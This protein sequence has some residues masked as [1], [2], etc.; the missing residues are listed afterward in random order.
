MKSAQVMTQVLHT[1]PNGQ[2]LFSTK[3]E[4]P[5][6]L[7][8]LLADLIGLQSLARLARVSK[9]YNQLYKTYLDETKAKEANQ[10]AFN[11]NYAKYLFF[12]GKRSCE[13]F[14]VSKDLAQ[15]NGDKDTQ[16]YL[17]ISQLYAAFIKASDK[18]LKEIISATCEKLFNS[19]ASQLS[20]KNI[21]VA[22]KLQQL[23]MDLELIDQRP[24]FLDNPVNRRL[25]FMNSYRTLCLE[26]KGTSNEEAVRSSA[27]SAVC[28][29]L[30]TP[31]DIKKESEKNLYNDKLNEHKNYFETAIVPQKELAL[32]RI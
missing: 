19:F 30:K 29:L 25:T 28:F 26:A 10:K 15:L 14:I 5:V 18:K 3:R 4:F 11:N 23:M 24:Y 20:N 13:G 32:L 22:I 8:R 7:M 2:A 27:H 1:Y 9:A 12:T 17:L 6:D 31:P 16:F 21:L